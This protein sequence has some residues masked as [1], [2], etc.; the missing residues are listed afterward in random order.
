[1]RTVVKVDRCE[2]LAD[3]CVGK[4]MSDLTSADVSRRILAWFCITEGVR[5]GY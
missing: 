2:F 1:M 3:V 4:F 5:I